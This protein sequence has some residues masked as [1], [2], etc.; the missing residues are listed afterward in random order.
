MGVNFQ[1]KVCEDK[2]DNISENNFNL[3]IVAF[4]WFNDH[5]Q[6]NAWITSIYVSNNNYCINL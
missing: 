4:T 1:S 5:E 2:R 3:F 6:E